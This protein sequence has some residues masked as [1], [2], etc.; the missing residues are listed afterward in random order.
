MSTSRSTLR[1]SLPLMMFFPV[2]YVIYRRQTSELRSN[3]RVI[4]VAYVS[5]CLHIC[6]AAYHDFKVLSFIC[7]YSQSDAIRAMITMLTNEV[8]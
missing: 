8:Y 2:Q 1:V 3:E 6:S 4:S 5:Y 7:L